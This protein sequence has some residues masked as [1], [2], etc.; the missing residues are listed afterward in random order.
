MK[1]TIINTQRTKFECNRQ[2]I[3]TAIGFSTFA[4]N[5][6]QFESGCQFLEERFPHGT[7]YAKYFELYSQS[8]AFWKWWKAEWSVW[9]DDLVSYA[10]THQIKLNLGFYKMDFNHTRTQKRF[11]S[12]FHNHFLKHFQ[13]SN[14]LKN[15]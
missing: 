12:S 7:E 11:E 1:E 5:S 8:Q 4:Y 3:E 10:K 14:N 2:S 15:K 13:F 9:E 6:F